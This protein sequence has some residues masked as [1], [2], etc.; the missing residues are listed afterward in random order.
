M[1]SG[2]AMRC[3]NSG[4][5]IC[6]VPIRGRRRET[7]RGGGCRSSPVSLR[8]QNRRTVPFIQPSK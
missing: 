7:R 3:Q 4:E 6:V 5:L 2:S 1:N 8:R